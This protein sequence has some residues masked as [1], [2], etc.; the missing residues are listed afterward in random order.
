MRWLKLRHASALSSLLSVADVAIEENKDRLGVM[1]EHLANVNQE[2]A[3]TQ[4]RFTAKQHELETESHLRQLAKRETVRRG[5]A[6]AP[7]GLMRRPSHI[8]ACPLHGGASTVQEH[9]GTGLMRCFAMLKQVYI[10][11]VPA[12]SWGTGA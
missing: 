4:S 3:Y 7:D 5:Q 6:P 1:Q 9:S 10:A 12:H 2:L 11:I 8:Q